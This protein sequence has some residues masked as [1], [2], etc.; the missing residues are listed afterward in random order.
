MTPP[1]NRAAFLDN[2]APNCPLEVR[3]APYT[4]PGP[5]QLVVKTRAVAVNPVDVYKQLLG[6]ALL[7]YVK[8]PCVQ[9]SD[10]AGDVVEV[11]SGVE[12]FQVGDRVLSYAA[13]TL[14]F[15]NDAAEGAFQHYT[16][17]R[18]FLTAK[19]P[20][21]VS[22]E[23]ASVLP[24]CFGTAAYGLFHRDFLGLDPPSVPAASP[25]GR[26]VVITS[27]ASSVGAS[28]VQL[29]AAAG[30]EVYSTSSPKNFELVKRLGAAAVFDYHDEGCADAIAAALEGKKVAGALSINPGGVAICAKVLRTTDS[31]KYIADAGPPPP[32]GYPEDIKSRFIDILDLGKPESVVGAIFRDF[33]PQALASGQL[34]P[35]PEPKVVGKGLESLQDAYGIRLQGVSAQKIVVSLD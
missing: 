18:D 34:I 4:P 14:A 35:E 11:G 19:I 3:E 31:V 1:S 2:G 8:F 9:G 16:V 12:G 30:Y 13:G 10:L 21:A 32:E 15:G 17:V 33:V 23:R 20:E 25:K 28:A 7:P 6:E 27:G 5:N 29:A 24:L 22:Y 26:A